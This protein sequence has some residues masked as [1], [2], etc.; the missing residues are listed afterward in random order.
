M[1]IIDIGFGHTPVGDPQIDTLLLDLP[2]INFEA[3][4]EIT[5]DDPG[6]LVLTDLTTQP[7]RPATIKYGQRGRANIY[8]GSSID[9]QSY[10]A[11]RSGIDT[12]VEV[13]GIVKFTD[14]LSVVHYA[15]VRVALNLMIPTSLAGITG[16]ALE[17]TLIARVVAACASMGSDGIISGMERLGH[18]VLRR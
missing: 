5:Q 15:P 6:V 11:D 12:V 13:K 7:G 16:A 14:D 2:P 17:T 3:D 18:G 9:T 4:F 1:S 10:L 8:A